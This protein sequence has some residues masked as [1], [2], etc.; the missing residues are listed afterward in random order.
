MQNKGAVRLFAILLALVC[1]YQL[2]FTYFTRSVESDAKAFANGD[3]QKE[4]AYLDSIANEP[5]YNFLFLKKYTYMECKSNEINFGLDLKGG[6]NL[7]LEVK[8]S[9]IVKALSNY[10]VDPTFTQAMDNAIARE[11]E[12]ANEDFLK[13]FREEFE[14]VNPNG[15]LATIFA[16]VDLKDRITRD[17][18]NSDVVSV[19]K[20]ETESAIQNAFNVLRTR[21]DRFGVTQPNIQRLQDKAGRILVEL[22]GVTEPARVRK[23]LQGT[24]SLEFWETYNNNEIMQSLIEVEAATREVVE[25]S[26]PAAVADSA[27]NSVNDLLAE[28]SQDSTSVQTQAQVKSIASYLHFTP[29]GYGPVVGMALKKDMATIDAYLNSDKVRRI[30]PRDLKLLWTVKAIPAKRAQAMFEGINPKEEVY[31]LV[32]IKSTSTNGR[33]PLEGDVITNAKSNVSQNSASYEVSMNMNSEGTRKWAQLTKANLGKSIAIVL[34]GFVYSFPTVQSEISGGSSQITGDFTTEEAQDLANVLKSGKLP[35]PATIVEDNVVGP[36]LGQEAI[37]SGLWSFLFAFIV[38]LI[39]MVFYYGP[40]AGLVADLALIANLFFIAGV[41]AS[42]GAV[43]TLPGIAG[44]VLTIGTAVDANV[45]IFERIKEEMRSG[46]NVANAI[47]AGY[48]NA[49]SAIVDANVTTFLTALILFLVGTGP[50]KGFATTLMI[51]VVSSFFTAVFMSRLFIEHFAKK[52]ENMKFGNSLTEHFLENVHID[53]IGKKK[54]YYILSGLVILV[55]ICSFAVRGLSW[56]IDFTGG[57]VFVVRFQEPVS[58]V[59]VQNSLLAQFE[60]SNVEVKT[61]GTE[62]QVRIATNY[63]L[64]NTSENAQEEIETKLYEGV[65]GF[66]PADVDR[67]KFLSDYR[68]SSQKVGPTIAEDIMESATIAIIMSLI[69]MFLYILIRFKNWQYGMGATVAL[70]HDTVIVLGMFSLLNSI[71]PFSMEIDQSFIAA[72]LTIVGYSINDTVVVFDRVREFIGLHPK[73]D[74]K[75]N[76]NGAISSTLSRTINTSLT[77]FFVLLV[78][79]IFGGEVIRGFVFGLL[80]G[81]VVG[82]YSSVFIASPVAYDL[83]KR[84]NK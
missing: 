69:V 33:A 57:Q 35:A 25:T 39:Y 30:L 82:T 27:N 74:L 51:G 70:I 6:M 61:Y 19:L 71:M 67:E 22:P 52:D 80:I 56:G 77:T 21:I 18:S 81:T 1:L 73:N 54:F 49:M 10:S 62:N 20:E 38:V 32:A 2:S 31:E 47:A 5:I 45:I 83:L 55:S 42:F 36:S 44:I 23:L 8:V 28:T 4:A 40:K 46:K 14:K 79:F 29:A 13:I 3:A 64:K 66:L 48:E 7:V 59:D 9:D 75:S 34:D 11:N 60:E 53:F 84:D 63:G 76:V 68:M 58:S 17:M 12:G 26:A 16:T 41:L 72:I 43:L 37:E 50:I 24:A 78:I 15:Q 65:K